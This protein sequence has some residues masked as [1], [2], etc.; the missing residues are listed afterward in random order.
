MKWSV[1]EPLSRLF[2]TQPSDGR[3]EP[4]DCLSD[5][6]SSA[7]RHIVV[8]GCGR[9]GTTLLRII[10]DSHPDVCCGPESDLF[11]PH[12]VRLTRLADKFG[13]AHDRL[14]AMADSIS[15][16]VD[17]IDR[18]AEACCRRAGKRIWAEKTPDNILGLEWIFAH[19]PDAKFVHVLRDGRDVACS[20]RN[21]PRYK[22]ENGRRV[23]LDTNNPIDKCAARWRDSL[24]SAQPFVQDPRFHTVRYEALT[25]SP[26]ETIS[27][28]LD[29]LGL[30]WHD[31]VLKHSEVDTVFRDPAA[32]PQ[33]AEA[34]KPISKDAAGRW[35]RDLSA[36]E[37]VQFKNVAG[38]L[39]VEWG[40][41]ED[42]D[43]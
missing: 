25:D 18:F 21:H 7:A 3:P 43:W 23:A 1:P 2:R 31:N 14:K 12:P 42:Q 17:F 28:L 26:R 34:L 4:A 5:G 16:R 39:L 29:F 27:A 41:A 37:K 20:L 9:S 33:N 35:K 30:P 15:C 10:L 24:R 13:F 40:Y 19:F 8:G 38:D 32:F 36:E 22:M 11:R 6:S